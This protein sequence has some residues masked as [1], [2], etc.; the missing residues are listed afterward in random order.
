MV[1]YR[2]VS[3][4]FPFLWETDAQPPARWHGPGD[5]PVHYLADTP[6]GAWAEVL[7]HQ[8]IDDRADVAGLARAV[9]AVELPDDL[10]L[11]EPALADAVLLGDERSY[12]ACRAEAARL[13][14]AGAGGLIAPGAAL[15]PGGAWAYVVNGG[16]HVAARRDGRVI[17]LFGG[18]PDVLGYR[19][20]Q[21]GRPWP[22]LVARVRPL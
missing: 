2:A 8:E 16:E 11:T 12:P 21:D 10:R 17:V 13:R 22:D 9:W 20:V 5:G 7:R 14:A 18:R 15:L 19:V 3:G 4:L 6:E 1:A